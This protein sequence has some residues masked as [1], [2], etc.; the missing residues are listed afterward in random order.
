MAGSYVVAMPN[1][2]SSTTETTNAEIPASRCIACHVVVLLR[3]ERKGLTV[4]VVGALFP[5]AV[6]AAQSG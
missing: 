4:V 3:P 1:C 6:G 2:R 5:L